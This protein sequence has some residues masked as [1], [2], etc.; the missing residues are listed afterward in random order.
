M[1]M[2]PEYRDIAKAAVREAREQIITYIERDPQFKRSHRPIP[3]LENAPEIVRLMAKVSWRVGVGPMAAVAGAIAQYAAEQLVEAGAD[4]IIFDNGG[5]IAMYLAHPA[6][7]G[8]YS[9][10]NGPNSLGFKITETDRFI[11]LCTSSATVGPSF[12]YG[13]TDASVVYADDVAF[14]DAAATALGNMVTHN[15][16]E[17]VKL[18]LDEI[19]FCG[20][21]GAMVVIGDTIGTCGNLPEIVP[22]RVDYGLITK[23]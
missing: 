13:S 11:G 18:S 16:S 21:R 6:I 5:D 7:V 12:S 2:S 8:L 15:D 23:G 4:H 19:L 22:A 14:A 1:I 17:L 9:G 3:V 10:P 20:V